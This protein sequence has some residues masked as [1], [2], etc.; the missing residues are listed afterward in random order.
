M[1]KGLV[2]LYIGSVITTIVSTCMGIFYSSGG[3]PR[4]VQNIYSQAVTLFGDG[5]YVNDSIMKVGATKGADIAVLFFALMLIC[6][7]L[8]MKNKPFVPFIQCGLLSIMLYAS[9]CVIMGVTF[10][11]LYLLYLLQFGCTFFAFAISMVDLLKK[12][13]FEKNVYDKRLT[14]TAIFLIIGGC[15]VLQWLSYILPVVISG[16]PMEII[17]IYT[18]EPTF[19]IDLAII[20]PTTIYCGVML[21]RKKMIAYQLTPVLLLLLSGVAVCVIFQTIVQSNLGIVL[22][23][24]HF[25]GLVILF[26]ALGIIALGLNIK[27]LKHAK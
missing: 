21:L 4:T 18:T 7:M 19:A 14:G 2:L 3:I 8:F 27:L 10:N 15:S 20:L 26:V 25:L 23:L 1:K 24:S 16:T 22:E 5:V 9:T 17:D 13:S 11:R 6:T 12:E